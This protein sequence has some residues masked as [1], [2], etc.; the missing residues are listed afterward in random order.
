MEENIGVW[1]D[2]VP[3]VN[4]LVKPRGLVPADKIHLTS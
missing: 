3:A 1:D 4:Y 2:G